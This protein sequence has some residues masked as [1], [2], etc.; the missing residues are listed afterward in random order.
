MAEKTNYAIEFRKYAIRCTFLFI[1]GLVPVFVF[2]QAK[3]IQISEFKIS[4][5]C[6]VDRAVRLDLVSSIANLLLMRCLSGENIYYSYPNEIGC[7]ILHVNRKQDLL[8]A[9]NEKDQN[10]CPFHQFMVSQF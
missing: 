5:Y 1:A 9:I 3:Q 6:V 10:P 2:D 4:S 7:K 8:T